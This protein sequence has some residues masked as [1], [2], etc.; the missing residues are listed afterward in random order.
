M[1]TMAEEPNDMKPADPEKILPSSL[2]RQLGKL[3]TEKELDVFRD[4]LPDAFLSDASEGLKQV[5]D[6]RQLDAVLNHL[7][8]HMHQQLKTRKERLGRRP[9]GDPGWSYWAILIILILT[10]CTFLV[11]R[12]LLHH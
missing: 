10:I 11:I 1:I 4:Q 7:N 3:M 8:H 12:L 9:F 6:E 5:Q 2:G